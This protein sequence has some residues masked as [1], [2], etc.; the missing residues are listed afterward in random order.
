M[1]RIAADYRINRKAKDQT[2][3]MSIKQ[4]DPWATVDKNN[5]MLQKLPGFGI[6]LACFFK[7]R[8]C[9]H[10]IQAWLNSQLLFHHHTHHFLRFKYLTGSSW[11]AKAKTRA[12]IMFSFH[13]LLASDNCW[14]VLGHYRLFLLSRISYNCNHRCYLP[15]ESFCTV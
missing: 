12:S 15:S 7:L 6:N 8:C 13:T 3:E 9:Q 5:T 10:V 1:G 4:R 14:S 2:Q 11:L